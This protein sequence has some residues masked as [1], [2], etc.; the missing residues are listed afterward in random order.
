MGKSLITK[1]RIE[2][3][4]RSHTFCPVSRLHIAPDSEE[5]CIVVELIDQ[6]KK[7]RGWTVMR[8]VELGQALENMSLGLKAA[9]TAESP[10]NADCIENQK[11]LIEVP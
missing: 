2:K 7:L 10:N 8:A 5:P 3:I 11:S 4:K 6:D 9:M 1:E